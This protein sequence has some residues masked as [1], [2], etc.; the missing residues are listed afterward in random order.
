MHY[1]LRYP[2]LLLLFLLPLGLAT[3][4]YALPP[5]VLSTALRCIGLYCGGALLLNVVLVP[6]LYLLRHV[7]LAQ[8]QLAAVPVTYQV[9]AGK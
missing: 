1:S 2:T 9:R 5:T 7:C 6:V 3:L 8:P 4:L